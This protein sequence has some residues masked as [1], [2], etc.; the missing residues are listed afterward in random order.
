MLSRIDGP[1]P[2]VDTD[3]ISALY[4][5]SVDLAIPF[6]LI[7]V[8]LVEPHHADFIQLRN[9]DRRMGRAAASRGQ[10]AVG[11]QKNTDIVGNRIGTDQDQGGFRL[12]LPEMFDLFFRINHP[13][14]QGA[15]ADPDAHAEERSFQIAVA[16]KGSH[17]CGFPL[18]H[19][20]RL[21]D[22]EPFFRGVLK[23]EF[24]LLLVESFFIDQKFRDPNQFV[25]D[26]RKFRFQGDQGIPFLRESLFFRNGECFHKTGDDIFSL[27]AE[28]E[29]T[30]DGHIL[31]G[32][33][34][35]PRKDHP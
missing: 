32:T 18:N 22:V 25:V 7:D 6:R 5:F 1:A 16:D 2:A 9:R 12:L 11:L 35:I 8:K 3:E 33:L 13:S 26:F 19:V 10:N 15:T 17:L 34:G 31:R 29:I 24:D 23:G 20:S 27:N 28:D 21:E 30:V 14:G 4:G